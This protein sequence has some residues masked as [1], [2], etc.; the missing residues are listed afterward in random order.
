MPQFP[1]LHNLELRAEGIHEP[2]TNEFAPGFVYYGLRRYRSGY[3]NDGNLL[4]NWVG[5]AGRGGQ[6][7]LTYSFSPRTRLQFQ[8]R[9]QEVSHKF[10]EGGRLGDYAALADFALSPKLS[11]SGSLQYEQWRFPV[12][13]PARQSNITAS[14]QLT[15]HPHWRLT[16]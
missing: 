10:I 6:A 11:L 13:S 2:L 15:F 8:Y 1:K 14:V 7:W 16:K 4:G 5:R 12:L 9:L 3:T